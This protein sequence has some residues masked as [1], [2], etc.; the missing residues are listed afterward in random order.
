MGN[1]N[2]TEDQVDAQSWSKT[3]SDNPFTQV[4]HADYSAKSFQAAAVHT[5]ATWKHTEAD[6]LQYSP[7]ARLLGGDKADAAKA[8]AMS[9]ALD[10]QYKSMGG[11]N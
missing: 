4:A 5:E 8:E 11:G 6:A 1:P 7:E 10:E 3:V 2:L 9:K